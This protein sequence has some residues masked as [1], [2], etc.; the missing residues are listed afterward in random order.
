MLIYLVKCQI[1]CYISSLYSW[2]G[3]KCH[4]VRY[5]LEWKYNIS[6]ILDTIIYYSDYG[7]KGAELVW[8]LYYLAVYPDFTPVFQVAG[9]QSPQSTSALFAATWPH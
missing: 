1:P 5:Y 9:A 8:H 2:S 4:T 6:D 3:V 7:K